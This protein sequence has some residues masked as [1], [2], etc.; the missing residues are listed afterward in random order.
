MAESF[1]DFI[2]RRLGKKGGFRYLAEEFAE[3]LAFKQKNLN[4]K[5][6]TLQDMI[7]PPNH[8]YQGWHKPFGKM[9]EDD[10]LSQEASEPHHPSLK[11]A[12]FGPDPR[13]ISFFNA[14]PDIFRKCLSVLSIVY[15]KDPQPK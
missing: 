15:G 5:Q 3:R 10:F 9:I 1:C 4:F 2:L 11:K 7:S 6:V 8:T 13:I 14:N 12:G